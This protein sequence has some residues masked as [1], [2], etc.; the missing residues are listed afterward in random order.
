MK[1]NPLARCIAVMGTQSELARRLGVKR[2]VVN[3]WKTRGA[4]P[5]WWVQ[6]LHAL[7]NIPIEDLVMA[8]DPGT[9]R[10]LSPGKALAPA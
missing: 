9:G 4:I 7:T 10:L 8:W 6:P 1:Q 2:Q 3:E 5:R